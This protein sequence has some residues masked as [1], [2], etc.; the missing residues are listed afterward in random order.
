VTGR[1]REHDRAHALASLRTLLP[2]WRVAGFS[3]SKFAEAT[4]VETN[5][6]RSIRLPEN[7]AGLAPIVDE[8]AEALRQRPTARW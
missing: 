2:E 3:W 8:L 5:F 1:Q 4:H 7:D 6:R